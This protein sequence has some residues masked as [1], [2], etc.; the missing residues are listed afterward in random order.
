MCVNI[1]AS[2][3]ALTRQFGYAELLLLYW[4][5]TVVIGAF[6]VPKLLIA[7]LFGE[8]IDT[9]EQMLSAGKRALFVALLL[10]AYCVVFSVVWMLLFAGIG[11]LPAVLDLVDSVPGARGGQGSETDVFR[12]DLATAALAL[13]HGV[14]F[15]VN[16]LLGREFR[17]GSLVKIAI[18]PVLRTAWIVGV[19]AGSAVIAL[20][21]PVVTTSTAFAVLVVVAK[22]TADVFAHLAERRRFG[23]SSKRY[24]TSAG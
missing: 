24:M 11:L 20:I 4:A 5:E 13:S 17:G 8:R 14:S 18:Q 7:A 1:G 21:Q 10:F 12:L 9:F 23:S 3:Y 15:V 2:V 22:V 19:I 16:F 6:N